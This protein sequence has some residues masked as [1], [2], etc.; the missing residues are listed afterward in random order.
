MPD[1]LMRSTTAAQGTIP[2]SE[3]DCGRIKANPLSSYSS[4]TSQPAFY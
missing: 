2:R 4:S 3:T 1:Q